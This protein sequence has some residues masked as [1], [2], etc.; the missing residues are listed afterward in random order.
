MGLGL[1]GSGM[2]RNLLA[3]G[4]PLTV[5][6]RSRARTEPFGADGARVAG[7]GDR[8]MAAVVEQFRKG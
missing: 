6:N 8:D 1:M 5:Y 3:S 7:H 2:A 4:Y